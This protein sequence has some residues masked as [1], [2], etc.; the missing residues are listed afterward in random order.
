[1]AFSGSLPAPMIPSQKLMS[2]TWMGHATCGLH[3]QSW[4]IAGDTLFTITSLI[5]WG[6][7]GY[8]L[9]KMDTSLGTP[10][11]WRNDKQKWAGQPSWYR[12]N[13]GK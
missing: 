12:V 13:T 1:M 3:P 6:T 2:A 7:V 5:H 8:Q 9:P 11:F 4:F 10:F